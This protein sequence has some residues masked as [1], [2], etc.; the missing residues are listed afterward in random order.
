MNYQNKPRPEAYRCVLDILGAKPE[1]C[2][3]VEDSVRN[4]KPAKEL[5]IVTVLVNGSRK[6]CVDFAID[7]V[8]QVGEVFRRVRD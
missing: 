2:L 1:E 6:D 3:L 8:T 5:G 7:N 4:L